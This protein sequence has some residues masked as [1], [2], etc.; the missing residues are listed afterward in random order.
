MYWS[1]WSVPPRIVRTKLDGTEPKVIVSNSGRANS[2]T[3]DYTD[4]RLY[5]TNQDTH[6]IESVNLDG[7]NRQRVL[8]EDL[9]QPVSITLYDDFIYWTDWET[10]TI[11]RANKTNGQNRTKIQGDMQYIM[12]LLVFH[13]SRQSGQYFTVI[14]IMYVTH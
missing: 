8:S 3:I 13:Q 11:E 4:R 14:I 1:D 5:W 12:D 7:T 2:L 9:P 10:Q 6:R